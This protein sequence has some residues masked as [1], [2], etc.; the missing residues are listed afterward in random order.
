MNILWSAAISHCL[1]ERQAPDELLTV[2]TL[3]AYVRAGDLA[4][5]S[6]HQPY[7]EFSVFQ[8]PVCVNGH[9]FE[10]EVKRP[11]RARRGERKL[12]GLYRATGFTNL[13]YGLNR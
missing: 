10:P 11:F 5:P 6:G 8:G 7:P 4:C 3:A 9:Q 2:E 1:A 13:I 12:A